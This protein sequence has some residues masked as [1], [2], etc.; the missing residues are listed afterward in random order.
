MAAPSFQPTP[1]DFERVT[2]AREAQV[3]ARPSLS[4]WQDA[5]IRLKANG[6]ALISLYLVLGIALFTLAGPLVWRV[7]PAAQDLDQVSRP[8]G[9]GQSAQVD[10]PSTPWSPPSVRPE[11]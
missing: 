7:D 8:P 2:R 4:Y 6:R 10:A 5:W 1:L 9:F 11:S 3:I